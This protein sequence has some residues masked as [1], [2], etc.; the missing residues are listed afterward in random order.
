LISYALA[1]IIGLLGLFCLGI[2]LGHISGRS[3]IGYGLRT[4][5][6]GVIAIAVNFLL[7]Q[8]N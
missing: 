4:T 5:L 1:L 8:S 7:D 3:L 6:A 2:F